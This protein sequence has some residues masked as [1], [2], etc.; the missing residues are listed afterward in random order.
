MVIEFMQVIYLYDC[1]HYSLRPE[2]ISKKL[3]EIH[4]NNLKHSTLPGICK[5]CVRTNDAGDKLV[6]YVRIVDI[7]D[8][9]QAERDSKLK[10]LGI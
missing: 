6:S 7:M 2:I 10:Q 9:K 1:G 3:C 8:P 5:T 4:L